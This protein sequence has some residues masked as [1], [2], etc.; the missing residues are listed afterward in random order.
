M[1]NLHLEDI[2]RLNTSIRGCKRQSYTKASN[3]FSVVCEFFQIWGVFVHCTFG[4]IFVPTY[5][6]HFTQSNIS[7][8]LY[9]KQKDG[10][11]VCESG[12]L[13]INMHSTE[14]LC[15]AI[16][17]VDEVITRVFMVLKD[18]SNPVNSCRRL[19]LANSPR[20]A[21]VK[22]SLA[23]RSCLEAEIQHLRLFYSSSKL[24]AIIG[25]V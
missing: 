6:Q 18:F 10:Q 21:S 25:L 17:N 13:E 24:K 14:T 19:W 5:L 9:E 8:L 1:W 16:N 3:T 20:L 22:P 15:L 2:N 11:S 7:S 12:Q 23:E 4:Q